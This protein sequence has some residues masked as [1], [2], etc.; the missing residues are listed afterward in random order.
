MLKDDHFSSVVE[1]CWD[2]YKKKNSDYTRGQRV[3]K[4]LDNFYQA[5]EHNG[6]TVLQAWGV[7]F[8]KH[9]SAVW[10][11]VK[12]GKVESEPI[13][14]RLYD[15]INYAILLLLWLEERHEHSDTPGETYEKE[16]PSP[17]AFPGRLSG[18][19]Y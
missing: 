5:A 14:Q 6:V 19:G 12:D 11:F 7:Y 17:Q 10:A 4:P 13:E 15:V 1:A 2:I 9:V 16:E 8:Y 3:E 18:T